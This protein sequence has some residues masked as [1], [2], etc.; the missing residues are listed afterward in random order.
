MQNAG[1]T[2]HHG[3]ERPLHLRHA[4]P[5][6]SQ[7]TIHLQFSERQFGRMARSSARA[8]KAQ[9]R[10]ECAEHILKGSLDGV[11]C[12]YA[13]AGNRLPAATTSVTRRFRG[14]RHDFLGSAHA[15]HWTMQSAHLR[16]MVRGDP[17]TRTARRQ[18]L[19]MQ[20]GP[21]NGSSL[22][23]WRART[24]AYPVVPGPPIFGGSPGTAR[25]FRD[26]ATTLSHTG[27]RS[28]PASAV[29]TR[30][31]FGLYERSRPVHRLPRR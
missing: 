2:D 26:A 25:L 5:P 22:G 17:P 16:A 9:F 27:R 19:I 7:V 28:R 18:L 23:P 11:G 30:S 12:V 13:F 4:A 20:R 1:P 15:C 29:R 21:L 10:G 6:T 14:W 24:V 31:H 3:G 8:L